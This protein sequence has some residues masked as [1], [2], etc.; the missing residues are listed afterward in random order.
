MPQN[1]RI[2]HFYLNGHLHKVLHVNRAEDTVVAHDFV[3]HK[4]KVYSWSGVKREK[5]NAFTVREAA[6]LVGRHKDRIKRYMW[7]GQI[8]FPQQDYSLTSGKPGRYFFSEDD[9]MEIRDFLASVHI[10]RPRKDGRVTNNSIP[11]RDEFRA[12]IQSGRVLYVKEDDKFVP[13]WKAEDW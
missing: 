10:G 4:R 8:D 11:N 9:M 7:Q 1:R 3:D 5:Q 12:M 2:T 6:R 13:V